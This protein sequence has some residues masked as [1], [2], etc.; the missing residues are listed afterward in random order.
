LCTS[1][2]KDAQVEKQKQQQ[3]CGD[4]EQK[5][6]RWKMQHYTAHVQQ[7]IPVCAVLCGLPSLLVEK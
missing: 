7:K 4:V 1:V 6:P 5:I 3:G 2:E